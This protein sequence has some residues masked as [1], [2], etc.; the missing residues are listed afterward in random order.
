MSYRSL[1]AIAACVGGIF[2]SSQ[3][4]AL[5]VTTDDCL[6]KGL[7]AYV[8]PKGRVTCGLCPGQARAVDVPAGATALCTDDSWSMSATRRGTCSGHGRVKVFIK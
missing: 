4:F 2:A 3:T 7:C 5:G 6:A 8:S 1:M